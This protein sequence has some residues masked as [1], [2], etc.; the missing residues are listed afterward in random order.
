MNP[1]LEFKQ[2]SK[3]FSLNPSKPRSFQEI[4]TGWMHHR[5]S[6]KQDFWVLRDISL[7]VE[8]G[9]A[10]GVIGAN[11]AGKSTLLKLAAK[12]IAPT[13]GW[14][15][16]NGRVGALLEVGVG[17]HPDL[18]G[19]ENIHLSGAI[20]GLNR[21]E[22]DARLDEIVAFSEVGDFID[23]PVRH[24]SSG[25]LVRLGFSVATSV[26]PDILLVDEVLAVGDWSFHFKCI[27]RIEEMQRRGT[28]ILYVSHNLEEVRRICARAFWID[29]GMIRAQGR[30]DEV[31]R[32]YLNDALQDRGI[33][34]Q[35]LGDEQD[36]GQRMGSG[37][38]E[39]TEAETLDG[40]G[41]PC[42]SFT[43]GLPFV[44]RM[45]Y[46]CHQPIEH[47]AFGLGI[48]TEDNIWVTSPNSIEQNDCLHMGSSGSIYYAVDHL[49]LKA[50][51]YELTVAVF[52]PT[53][54]AYKPYDHWHRKYRF[55]VVE[56]QRPIP[57]DGLVELP[58]Q[59]MDD[60]GW[61]KREAG[62]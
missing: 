43:N 48:Y 1:I 10:V 26:N 45:D 25:M 35:E 55:I 7:A 56:R 31:V 18:T 21:R 3:R 12:I 57:Q 9:E 23:V 37:E 2:I 29:G 33:Q 14:V 19:R 46:R 58:H 49:P 5:R 22:M 40:Q 11:G 59:W 51:N 16:V 52:D 28:S 4:V 54:S 32:A 8:P 62:G 53:A 60:K 30:P 61:A 50:G 44:V 20:I 34:V 42:D 6:E 13:Q 41:R 38:V 47:W 17:F 36:R 24:Y 27:E 15:I 39:I